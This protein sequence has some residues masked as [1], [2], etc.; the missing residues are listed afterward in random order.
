LGVSDHADRK[1]GVGMSRGIFIT[2]TDTG[3]GKTVAAAAI[4]RG[5]KRCG[6]RAGAMKPIETGCM[7]KDGTLEPADGRFLKD[8]SGMDDPLELITPMRFESPLAPYIAARREGVPVEIDKIFSSYR[9][10]SGRY[11]FMVV[12]GIGGVLVPIVRMATGKGSGTYFV[13]DLIKD[14][15]LPAV[16]VT[17]PTLGTINHTLLTVSQLLNEGIDV[18]GII[19][20]FNIPPDGTIAEKTNPQA[21]RELCPVPIIGVIPCLK[22]VSAESIEADASGCI[23]LGSIASYT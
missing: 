20:N 17:R 5:L 22:A 9:E 2:A 11:D 8:V 16:V 18:K 4:V 6:I 23:E 12:E 1:K 15:K 19:I 21:L 14:L 10:L 13:I 3:A 7:R